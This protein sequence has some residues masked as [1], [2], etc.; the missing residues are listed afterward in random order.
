MTLGLIVVE[1]DLA[2]KV[3]YGQVD[4][5]TEGERTTAGIVNTRRTEPS[6]CNDVNSAAFRRGGPR[7]RA[8]GR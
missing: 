3:D 4:F 5:D 1:I 2:S 7:A 8:L 6:R